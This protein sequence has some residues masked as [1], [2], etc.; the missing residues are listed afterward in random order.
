MLLSAP[1]LA[2]DGRQLLQGCTQAQRIVASPQVRDQ[3]FDRPD[4]VMAAGHC[5]GL[6]LGLANMN[7]LWQEYTKNTSIF[8]CP[9]PATTTGHWIDAVVTY[10]QR[11]PEALTEEGIALASVALTT[12]FPCRAVPQPPRR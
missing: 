9:P 10:L 11:H 5:M 6:V 12:A 3:M 7:R 4:M 2:L 8:F 1:A